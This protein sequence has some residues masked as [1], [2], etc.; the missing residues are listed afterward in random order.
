MLYLNYSLLGGSFITMACDTSSGYTCRGWLSDMGDTN[1]CGLSTMG[2][3]LT[4]GVELGANSLLVKASLVQNVAK[5]LGLGQIL[6]I[7]F[8]FI[9]VCSKNPYLAKCL[10][11][12]NK[13][14]DN[15]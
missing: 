4:W 6:S 1:S 10:Q 2:G 14:I 11:I 13:S 8:Y 15:S 5:G 3:P 7:F 12:Q 9:F